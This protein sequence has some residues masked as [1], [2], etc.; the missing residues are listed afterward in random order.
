MHSPPPMPSHN[1]RRPSISSTMHWLSRKDSKPSPDPNGL[2]GATVVRTPE[3]ALRDTNV[4]VTYE[5][6][7]QL[8][9]HSPSSSPPLPPLPMPEE[10]ETELLAET[11]KRP[12]KPYRAVPPAPSPTPSSSS[13]LRPS[14]KSR[15]S[16]AVEDPPHVPPLPSH[17]PLSG[18]VAPFTPILVSA[19]PGPDIDP[20]RIIVTLETCT[21][22]YKSTLST[23]SSRPSFL[24]DYLISLTKQRSASQASSVYSTESADVE[25]YRNHLGSQGLLQTASC[26]TSLHIF[27]DRPSAP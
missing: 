14:L 20:S 6:N 3:D 5:P 10:E 15:S 23:L 26:S 2:Q 9:S 19:P 13:S 4:R 22:T 25:T 1:P 17:I 8:P 21:S 27:L 12:P 18:P 7:P 11:P 24:A 16:T